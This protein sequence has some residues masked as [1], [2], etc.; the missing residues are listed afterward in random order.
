MENIKYIIEKITCIKLWKSYIV[1]F[2]HNND[3]Y[4]IIET[5]DRSYYADLMINERINEIKGL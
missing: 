4:E 3:N 2:S 5:K 1:W